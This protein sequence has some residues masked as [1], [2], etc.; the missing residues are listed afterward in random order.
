MYV[1]IREEVITVLEGG[2]SVEI[3]D[4]VYDSLLNLL[5]AFR[6]ACMG[7]CRFALLLRKWVFWSAPGPRCESKA[8]E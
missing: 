2:K 1:K 5:R 7:M 3:C 8:L 4:R 6:W